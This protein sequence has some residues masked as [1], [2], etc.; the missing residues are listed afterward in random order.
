MRINNITVGNDQPFILIAGPCAI[1]NLND[2]LY[3]AENI[4][5]ICDKLNIQLIFKSSFDKA[6][7]TSLSSHR[8]IGIDEG[9]EILL[10]VKQEF[11]LTTITDIHNESQCIM[12][13]KVVDILQ[14]PAFLC[15]QTDLLIAAAKTD[16]V[17]NV[18]KVNF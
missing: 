4:K 6:N 18:K 9:L 11:N 14:I 8:G 15:R 7:R 1:E 12:A 3:H 5:N 10:K 13:S 2:T 17:I 16:C